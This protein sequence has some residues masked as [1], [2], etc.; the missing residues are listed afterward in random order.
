MH[1]HAGRLYIHTATVTRGLPGP[2]LFLQ[3][4]GF[5]DEAARNVR[6]ETLYT[7]G[8]GEW[9]FPHPVPPRTVRDIY[10]PT[11]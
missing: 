3:S 5:V 4:L 8:Y 9:K 7:E 2:I 6:Y 1:Q 10:Q 11:P